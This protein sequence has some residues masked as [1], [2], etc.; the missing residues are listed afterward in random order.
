MPEL[1]WCLWINHC[2]PY[3]QQTTGNKSSLKGKILK[4]FPQ[5]MGKILLDGGC[6]WIFIHL[7]HWSRNSKDLS[8]WKD[9]H[10]ERARVLG[11]KHVLSSAGAPWTLCQS[12]VTG[13]WPHP[14]TQPHLSDASSHFYILPSKTGEEMETCGCGGSVPYLWCSESFESLYY[15]LAISHLMGPAFSRWELEASFFSLPS[16]RAQ[17]GDC[18]SPQVHSAP[19]RQ[20]L[21]VGLL[22]DLRAFPLSLACWCGIASPGLGAQVSMVETLGWWV[23]RWQRLWRQQPWARACTEMRRY[24]RAGCS[25][26]CLVMFQAGLGPVSVPGSAGIAVSFL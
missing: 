12:G 14:L 18:R 20:E 3:I 10:H 7:L 22:S 1:T 9:K 4:E 6:G 5:N 21:K 25:V 19:Q 8:L 26:M 15:S 13:T 11:C 24:P 2:D 16:A 23:Q 17:Q